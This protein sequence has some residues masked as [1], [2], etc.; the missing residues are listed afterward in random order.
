MESLGDILVLGYGLVKRSV[1]IPQTIGVSCVGKRQGLDLRGETDKRIPDK[2]ELLSLSL[3]SLKVAIV[4]LR[5]WI[6]V[7]ILA[8]LRFGLPV[9]Y[10][11][12]YLRPVH[13][14]IFR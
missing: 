7:L 12:H 1:H 13:P 11:G 6:E 3:I 2:L 14:P 8:Q 5:G 4:D 9:L 10:I